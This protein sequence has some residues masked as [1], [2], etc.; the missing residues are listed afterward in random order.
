MEFR[1]PDILDSGRGANSGQSGEPADAQSVQEVR[2]ALERTQAELNRTRS[3]GRTL[4]IQLDETRRY[5]LEQ[6]AGG[7]DARHRSMLSSPDA[8]QS[9]VDAFAQVSS[10]LAGTAGDGGF[11]RS[12]ARLVARTHGVELGPSRG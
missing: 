9:W 3:Y 10:A 12:E 6:V 11:G 8:W 2:E 5:L 4:W 1:C 7:E